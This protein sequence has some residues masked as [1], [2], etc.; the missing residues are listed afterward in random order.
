[1]F[2]AALTYVIIAAILQ[3]YTVRE[4]AQFWGVLLINFGV[5][6]PHAVLF[7]TY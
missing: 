5:V 4:I 3:L 7:P 1:M 6:I 2:I